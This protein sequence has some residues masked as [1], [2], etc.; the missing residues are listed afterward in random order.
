MNGELWNIEFAT[1]ENIL[2]LRRA[3]INCQML[4]AQFAKITAMNTVVHGCSLLLSAWLRTTRK[5]R[6]L[7]SI[8]ATHEGGKLAV[9]ARRILK[10][11]RVADA[12]V[13]QELGP[14]NHLCRVFGSDEVRVLVPRAVRHQYWKPQ[15]AQHVIDLERPVAH[16]E[17]HLGRHH[18]V[19]GQA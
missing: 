19:K 10:E 11:R 8:S 17:A 18:H 14:G 9:E 7:K 15:A 5:Q 13:D 12:V 4:G 1:V 6:Y 2:E 16:S 3:Q